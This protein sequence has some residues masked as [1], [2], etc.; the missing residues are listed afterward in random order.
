MSHASAL[1]VALRLALPFGMTALAGMV[2]LDVPQRWAIIA[3]LPFV[4]WAAASGLVPQEIP[5][6]CADLR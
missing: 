5:D 4:I 1:C 3:M 6:A 2:F